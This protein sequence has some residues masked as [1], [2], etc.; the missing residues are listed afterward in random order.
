MA[1]CPNCGYEVEV[2]MKSWTIKPKTRKGNPPTLTIT[3]WVC[4]K[5]G[6]KFRTYERVIESGD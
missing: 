6:R 5:C 2:Y 1:K 3:Q 4:P